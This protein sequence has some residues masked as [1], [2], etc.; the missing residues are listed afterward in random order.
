LKVKASVAT[1]R[2][3]NMLLY[4]PNN[5]SFTV[6][7]TEMYEASHIM[8]RIDKSAFWIGGIAGNIV[9]YKG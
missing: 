4:S 8:F 6:S 7:M 5:K 9:V 3:N 2:H 1:L